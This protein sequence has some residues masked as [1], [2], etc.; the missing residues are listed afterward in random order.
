MSVP[1]AGDVVYMESESEKDEYVLNDTG[2]IW[3]GSARNNYGRPWNFGQ[4]SA[5]VCVQ[6]AEQFSSLL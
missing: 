6:T 1:I 4:V 3:I 2:N 5:S